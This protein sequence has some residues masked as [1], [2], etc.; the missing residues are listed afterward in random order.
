M[1]TA[2]TDGN[3]E[4]MKEGLMEALNDG[5]WS[6]CWVTRLINGKSKSWEEGKMV[7]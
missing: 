5:I 2:R 3:S 1:R 7:N 4:E 6:I